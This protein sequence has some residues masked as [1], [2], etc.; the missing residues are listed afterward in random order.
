[1]R[2]VAGGAQRFAGI[3][4]RPPGLKNQEK[5]DGDLVRHLASRGGMT[6]AEAWVLVMAARDP[7]APD[8]AEAERQCVAHSKRNRI[9]WFPNDQAGA[10]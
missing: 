3:G 7:A 2:R 10:A 6:E 4:P 9:G 8:H 1:M 5:A